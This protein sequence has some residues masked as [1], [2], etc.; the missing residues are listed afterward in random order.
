ME[1]VTCTVCGHEIEGS[2]DQK[3]GR[4]R[5]YHEDCRKFLNAVSL[6][7]NKLETF[8]AMNPTTEGKKKVRSLLWSL[9]NSMN[10]K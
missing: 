9:A 1:D 10:G 4:P 5:Q 2:G 8:R 7:Q 6:L 3:T